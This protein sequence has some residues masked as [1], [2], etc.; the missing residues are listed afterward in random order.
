[1]TFPEV[2]SQQSLLSVAWENP[3]STR[4]SPQNTLPCVTFPNS[5]AD[6]SPQQMKLS[7]NGSL[8]L[9]LS[10]ALTNMHPCRALP[11]AP[12]SK[13]P[14]EMELPDARRLCC[15]AWKAFPKNQPLFFHQVPALATS[16]SKNT[17][18]PFSFFVLG[19]SHALAG[20]QSGAE[21][22]M[23]LE[24]TAISGLFS[25]LLSLPRAVPGLSGRLSYVK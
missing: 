17:G 18:W 15:S 20:A 2:A 5:Y 11:C 7:C 22:H 23:W 24:L 8:T 9:A 14:Y 12:W 10:L 21:L 19:E 3:P 1:M 16:C 25:P 6:Y 4:I 13:M